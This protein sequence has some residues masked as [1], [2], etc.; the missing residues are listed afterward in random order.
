MTVLAQEPLEHATPLRRP[1]NKPPKA[2]V[3]QDLRAR[4]LNNRLRCTPGL[5]N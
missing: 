3:V 2:A 1:F 4:Q 5:S